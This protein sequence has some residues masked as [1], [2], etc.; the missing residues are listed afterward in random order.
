MDII[1][2]TSFNILNL[3]ARFKFLVISQIVPLLSKSTGYVRIQ[4]AALAKK[5]Y[6]KSFQLNRPGKAENMYYLTESGKELILQHSKVFDSDIKLPLG[7]P[8]LVKDYAHRK[9]MISLTIALYYHFTGLG[10]EVCEFMSY[11]DK[12]G[13]NRKSGNLEARTKIPLGNGFFIPDGIMISGNDKKTVWLIEQYCDQSSARV[14]SQILTKHIVCIAEGG[15]AIKYGVHANPFVLSCFEHEGIK[16]KVIEKLST[17]DTFK[18]FQHL[19]FFATLEELQKNG[20][21][22]HT[23]TRDPLTLTI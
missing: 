4:L 12:Q 11:F 1:N 16:R 10:I 2:D 18:A 21:A 20:N 22:W 9:S 17:N 19:F 15:T 13:D 23:V 8:L 6:I 14:V 3:L 7:Q 5:G